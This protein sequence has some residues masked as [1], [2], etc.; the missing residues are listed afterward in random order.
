MAGF[1]AWDATVRRRATYR[2]LFGQP[3]LSAKQRRANVPVHASDAAEVD[4]AA[5]TTAVKQ[6][7]LGALTLPL[8]GGRRR[9]SLELLGALDADSA[10]LLGDK[11]ALESEDAG[12]DAILSEFPP[13]LELAAGELEDGDDLLLMAVGADESTADASA[14]GKRSVSTAKAGAAAALTDAFTS[15][16]GDR[17]ADRSDPL[18]LELAQPEDLDEILR[19]ID[20]NDALSPA[21]KRPAAR[22][23]RQPRKE[24]VQAVEGVSLAF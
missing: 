8:A 2:V 17:H 15:R 9:N 5:T 22:K 19:L 3:L 6:E 18:A 20:A 1:S 21:V 24:P 10:L 4:A 12:E 7:P 14:L 11:T 13:V 23:P 16:S